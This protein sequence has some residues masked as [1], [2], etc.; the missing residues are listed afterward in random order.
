M[1]TKNSL[2]PDAEVQV[3]ASLQ[4][5]VEL[6]EAAVVR[7]HFWTLLQIPLVRLLIAV[8]GLLL[9]GLCLLV[10]RSLLGGP[11]QI[12]IRLALGFLLFSLALAPFQVWRRAK[13]HYRSLPETG[14]RGSY[15]IDENAFAWNIGASSGSVPWSAVRKTGESET[16]FYFLTTPFQPH[17]IPKDQLSQQQRVDLSSYLASRDR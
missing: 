5:P 17:V 16:A 15:T 3:Q 2:R 13:N 6:T 1:S 7:A 8:N 10:L 4:V 12:V 14:R 11:R 9:S